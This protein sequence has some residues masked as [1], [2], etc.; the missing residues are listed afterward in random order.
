[1]R[2]WE[3][4]L[5]GRVEPEAAAG[6]EQRP[7]RLDS[8][9]AGA[10]GA[11][12]GRRAGGL[13]FGGGRR[14]GRGPPERHVAQPQAAS[15]TL[16]SSGVA[17]LLPVVAAPFLLL[18]RNQQRVAVRVGRRRTSGCFLGEERSGGRGR[19]KSMNDWDGLLWRRTAVV[20][21]LSIVTTEFNA[22]CLI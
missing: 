14:P 21:D 20:V 4:E 12:P 11:G 15:G 9:T 7:D 1:M 13:A 8:S 5:G 6:G 16:G 17:L 2:T 22:G 18:R 10:G 19:R 3:V